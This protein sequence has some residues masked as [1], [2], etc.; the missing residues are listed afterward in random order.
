[1]TREGREEIR[2]ARRAGAKA[3]RDAIDWDTNPNWMPYIDENV[4]TLLRENPDQK[5]WSKKELRRYAKNILI[6][7]N[8]E[9]EPPRSVGSTH[10]W[11]DD[12]FK[13]RMGYSPLELREAWLE[14]A[15]RVL[16]AENTI[17]WLA[18]E[19][20]FQLDERK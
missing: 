14:A 9:M 18:D 15:H 5:K 20:A 13:K 11:S 4:S 6:D 17:R 2:K 3:A 19:L 10:G 7:L 12:Y 16:L 8:R 1:M